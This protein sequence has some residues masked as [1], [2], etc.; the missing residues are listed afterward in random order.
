MIVPTCR[1]VS[2]IVLASISLLA[3][4]FTSGTQADDATCGNP[5]STPTGGGEG[6][7]SLKDYPAA[8]AGWF[9]NGRKPSGPGLA[10]GAQTS[11]ARKL[12]QSYQQYNQ[13][14]RRPGLAAAPASWSPLGPVPQLSL[15]W[16]NVSGRVTSLAVDA[17]DQKH[18]L[19]VGTAFGGLWRTDDFTAMVP[20]FIPL[21]D[22]QWPSLAVGSIAVDTNRTTAQSPILYVG[23]GEANDSLDSY[24]GV[25]ILKSM[26]G[27]NTWALSTGT[28][29]LVPLSSSVGYD[30]DGPFVGAAVSKIV[31][32]PENHNHILASVSSS[33]LGADRSP[34]TAIYESLNAGDSWQPM[35]LEGKAVYNTT[36]L[37]YEPLRREFYAAVQGN[38]VYH[39][40]AGESDWK[41]TASPFGLTRIDG[42]NFDR[43][44][45][46][47]RVIDGKASIYVVI[48]AGQ[49]AD[50]DP[51]NYNL[52][53][54]TAN[55]SGIVKSSDGGATWTPVQAPPNL[56]GDGRGDG[57]GFYDQ[58]IAVPVATES[59]ILG[60]IDI[61]RNDNSSTASWINVTRAYDWADGLA[62]PNLHIHPDQHAIIVLDDADWIVGNDGGVWRTADGGATWTDLNTDIGSIQ[63]T[64]VTPLRPPANG[65]LAGSQ[66]NGTTL[67]GTIG[68]PWTTTLTGD[69]GFTRGN[70][71]QPTVYF[72]ER[73]NVSLCRS[74]DAGKV[75]KT[76]V[77]S[78]TIQ[79]RSPFYVP[80][81]LLQTDHDEIVLGTQK[82]W[83]GDAAPESA[84]LAWRPIS[85][86]LAPNGFVQAIAV[87][88]SAPLTIYVATSDSLV[89]IN[90]NVHAQN[91][92]LKWAPIKRSNLPNDRQYAAIAVDPNNAKVAY[93]GV[94]G[95]GLGHLFRTDN[96]GGSWHDVT[97]SVI[98]NGR[99]V[100]IDTPVNSILIDPA[101]PSDVYAATDIGVFVST[102]RGSTWLPYST[103]LPRT[104]VMEL[105]MSVDRQI[106][107]ATHGRGAWVITPI[108]H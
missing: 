97:P 9:L 106:V 56:F 96:S 63:L 85:G 90:S 54:P 3:L 104:A 32:D 50:K 108:S 37:I 89:Y 33:P 2:L 19:Y 64:S 1:T 60:G 34:K 44:S 4:T 18:V 42:T 103:D 11:P 53:K 88:P 101:V 30:L 23:T 16:G 13:M 15:Y 35:T 75:W 38:G 107:C 49:F 99:T 95:F 40:T 77:D 65:Y 91:V 12:L 8:R 5:V 73:F 86:L 20:H 81:L 21:G 61:W 55:D 84:G 51:R 98:V 59:I 71:R 94:Q 6:Q 68:Q 102:N 66:D 79:D 70:P 67:S 82:L 58:W 10:G 27:G 93:L 24:Y 72:T 78:D 45:L 100:Q 7:E 43:A 80:Y 92:A 52:S 14:S 39:L 28:G 105:K 36:D 69:G 87:A 57:Q 47:T 48:S 83:I 74:D 76:V 31:I 62:H 22:V 26:D 25:G 41:A 29:R 17:R 46:A